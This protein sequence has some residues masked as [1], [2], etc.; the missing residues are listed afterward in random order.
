V[1][2]I[3][4]DVLNRVERA[5][6]NATVVALTLGPRLSDPYPDD[7]RWTPNT[8]WLEPMGKRALA[9]KMALRDARRNGP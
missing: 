8:R 6:T 4:D 3:P 9:A 7:P 5:L 1:S 2:E